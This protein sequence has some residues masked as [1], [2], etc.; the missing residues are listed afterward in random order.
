MIFFENETV[1]LFFFF[2]NIGILTTYTENIG[3][4]KFIG[5]YRDSTPWTSHKTSSIF[6]SQCW[7]E[8][9]ASGSVSILPARSGQT[10]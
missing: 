6:W 2:L 7:P 9:G 10:E 3:I 1:L 4:F 8:S 5:K